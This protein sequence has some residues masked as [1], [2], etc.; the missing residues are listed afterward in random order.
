[1]IR[2]ADDDR[3]LP[4]TSGG[5]A[6]VNLHAQIDARAGSPLLLIDLLLLRGH[7]LGRIADYERAADLAG[8]LVSDTPG[9][10]A[11]WL[12]RAGA[13]AAFHRFTKALADLDAAERVGGDRAAVAGERAAILQATG[14]YAQAGNLYRIARASQPGFTTL[15]ALAVLFAERGRLAAADCLFTQARCRYRGTSPFPLAAL[16][17]RNGLMWCR[18]GDL[19]AA[20]S[21]LDA[22]VR[23]VPAYAPAQGRLAQIH[24]AHGHHQAAV[25]R[26]RPLACS[27]DDPEYAAQPAT[28]PT[29]CDSPAGSKPASRQRRSGE[30]EGSNAEHRKERCSRP[31]RRPVTGERLQEA[32]SPHGS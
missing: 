8:Q 22:A 26:L 23:R 16:D 1:M 24:T 14:C 21:W 20:R 17:Y 11:A 3:E 12:A 7:V 25:D 29:F 18:H 4:T 13:R 6:V 2:A 10:G 27:S 9:A 19:T 32:G 28:P 5:I 15:A 30:M 31:T